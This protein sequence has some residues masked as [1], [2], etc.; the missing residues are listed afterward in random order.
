[1]DYKLEVFSLAFDKVW[2]DG[3]IFKFKQN[4]ISG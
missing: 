3:R 1:M 2:H 4:N